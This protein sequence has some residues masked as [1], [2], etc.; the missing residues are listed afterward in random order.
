[1]E[2]GWWDG[3]VA[4]AGA[5]ADLVESPSADLDHLAELASGLRN[6]LRP[7]I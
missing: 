2:A 7:F 1:M 5:L 6:E 3:V 4:R